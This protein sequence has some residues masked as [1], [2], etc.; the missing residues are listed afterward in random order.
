MTAIHGLVGDDYFQDNCHW[1]EPWN[2][3]IIQETVRQIY[4]YNK[5]HARSILADN[6][7]WNYRMPFVNVNEINKRIREEKKYQAKPLYC[8]GVQAAFEDNLDQSVYYFQRAH[9]I[10]PDIMEET[11]AS[12]E[13]TRLDFAKNPWMV[14][15]KKFSSLWYRVWCCKGEMYRRK[16]D[17]RQALT[18]FQKSIQ[19]KPNQTAAYLLKGITCRIMKGESNTRRD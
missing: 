16:R 9:C 3:L 10:V 8:R 14:G 5:T 11:G 15:E 18:Y 6:S 17:Y 4:A 19:A 13:Q 7:H 12:M 2:D 1:F